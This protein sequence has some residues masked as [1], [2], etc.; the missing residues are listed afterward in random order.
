MGKHGTPEE[1]F[2]AKVDKT[3]TCWLWTAYTMPNGYGQFR[4]EGRMRLAHRLSYEWLIGPIPTGLQLDHLC[5]VRHCVN[6]AHL[7]PVTTRINLLRG[8]GFSAANARKTH[9]ING[10]EFTRDNT[11]SWK[12]SIRICRACDRERHRVYDARDRV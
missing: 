10:H 4:Y 12:D 8:E 7:E 1:W 6:P 9:C 5:R 11:R 2:W 3:Q